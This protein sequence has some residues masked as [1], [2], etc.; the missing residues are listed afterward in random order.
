MDSFKVW[1]DVDG[2]AATMLKDAKR[3]M[4]DKKAGCTNKPFVA[5][6][7]WNAWAE[8]LKKNNLTIDY[9][10]SK[11]IIKEKGLPNP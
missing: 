7:L 8:Y 3:L 1:V 6:K 2:D 10:N 4:E 9:E 5:N 11:I